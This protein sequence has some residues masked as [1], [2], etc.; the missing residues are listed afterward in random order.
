[1][2]SQ[3][4]RCGP[5]P[6]SQPATGRPDTTGALACCLQR[7]T[8]LPSEQRCCGRRDPQNSEPTCLSQESIR[9]KLTGKKKGKEEKKRRTKCETEVQKA[10]E[11]T[12]EGMAGRN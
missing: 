10:D 4:A 3:I 8:R 11:K 12:D 6:A 7:Q 2:M 5:Q 9:K 1:M